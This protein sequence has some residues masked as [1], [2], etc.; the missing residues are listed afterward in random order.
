MLM[1]NTKNKRLALL[2]AFFMFTVSN[3]YSMSATSNEVFM[4]ESES[5]I[6]VSISI[7]TGV[8]NGESEEYVYDG[9]SKLSKLTWDLDNVPVIGIDTSVKFKEK[10]SLNFS[11]WTKISESSGNM[12]DYDWY[13]GDDNPWTDYSS[14][15]TELDEAYMLD[16]NM[17]YLLYKENNFSLSGELGFRHDYYKWNAYG[18]YAIYDSGSVDVDFDDE[19]NISYDQ[20]FYAPYLG[21]TFNTKKNKWI[22]SSYIR[23]SLWAWGEAEDTHYY[24]GLTYD[25]G[26]SSGYLSGSDSITFKD[27]FENIAYLSLG[28]NIGYM[29]MENLIINLSTDFQKYFRET[30]DDT[31]YYSDGTTEYYKDSAGTSNY[32]YTVSIGASYLF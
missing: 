29:V 10:F 4:V 12:E 5:K 22:I 23:G 25:T 31:A 27:E 26:S 3:S 2:A 14:H 16:I 9:S 19:K 6:P 18:G 20:E 1:V 11:G 7:S 32:S 30:G 13:N 17:S 15:N 24:P 8:L 21:L 28:L